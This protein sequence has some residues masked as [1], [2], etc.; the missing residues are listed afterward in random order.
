MEF[1]PL[2]V[3][4]SSPPASDSFFF[5]LLAAGGLYALVS[6]VALASAAV[7]DHFGRPPRREKA[8]LEKLRLLA[9]G[10]LAIGI[11]GTLGEIFE[12][13]GFAGEAPQSFD[14]LAAELMAGYPT[15]G[16]FAFLLLLAAHQLWTRY[17]D[18]F[19]L[20]AGELRIDARSPLGLS[21]I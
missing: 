7:G 13:Q 12:A 5:A 15:R 2:H 16:A 17:G 14:L 10:A 11:A 3:C 19:A 20:A 8:P 9:I 21:L 4:Y 1:G 18:P 6:I